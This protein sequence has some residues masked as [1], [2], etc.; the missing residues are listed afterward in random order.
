MAIAL[1]GAS[2][3]PVGDH[4]SLG[5]TSKPC[6]TLKVICVGAGASGLL[7][8]YKLQQ[9]FDDFQLEIFEKNPDVSGTWYENR[10][11]G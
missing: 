2:D 4:R 9:H 7:L 8:A 3:K 6:R 1:N 11:P 10:Y 5:S